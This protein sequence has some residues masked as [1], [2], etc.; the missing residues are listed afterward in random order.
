M[1]T[2]TE[3]TYS[4]HLS[5][6]KYGDDPDK[7]SAI[8]IKIELKENGSIFVTREHLDGRIEYLENLSI[9]NLCSLKDNIE[10]LIA[11]AKDKYVTLDA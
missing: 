2:K 6:G 8:N 5:L 10:W 4:L 1:K 11:K 3:K 9:E 7:F